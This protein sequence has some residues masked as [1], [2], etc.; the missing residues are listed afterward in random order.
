[1]YH[2]ARCGNPRATVFEIRLIRDPT[3]KVRAKSPDFQ[4]FVIFLFTFSFY[5]EY[6]S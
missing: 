3:K 1:M 2:Y 5:V 4:V 6:C